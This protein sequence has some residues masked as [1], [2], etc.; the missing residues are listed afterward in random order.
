MNKPSNW[1]YFDF[2]QKVSCKLSK[3]NPV[4]VW[5]FCMVKLV[6][7]NYALGRQLDR[8][9]GTRNHVIKSFLCFTEILLSSTIWALAHI[10][11]FSEIDVQEE[12]VFLCGFLTGW[13][14]GFSQYEFTES[15]VTQTYMK[16]KSGN[17][18]S[19]NLLILCKIWVRQKS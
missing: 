7:K 9:G 13:K 14:K 17:I 19:K 16:S 6:Q 4:T 15:F 5:Q 8:I 18:E 2:L 11:L 12:G 3:V 1:Y 10:G